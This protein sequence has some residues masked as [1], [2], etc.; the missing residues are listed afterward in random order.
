MPPFFRIFPWYKFHPFV[1][2]F[3]ERDGSTFLISLLM[4]HPD[5]HAVYERFAV[6]NQKG[7]DAEAQLA[8]A[9][10][11]FTPPLFSRVAAAGFKTKLVDIQDPDGFR[12]LLREKKCHIIHMYRRN[13][14]KAV[15]SRINARRL[16]EEVG[17]WNLYNE[18]DR[19]PPMLI[20]LHEFDAYLHERQRAVVDLQSFV[21][22]LQLPTLRVCYED[23]LTIRDNVLQEI[24][25]FLQV[26]PK[27]LVSK[28]IK[29]TSDNLRDVILNYD[30]LK[31][32]YVGTA[33]EDMFEEV[34]VQPLTD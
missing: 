18:K 12:L 15:V 19:M 4:S 34:I 2:L 9:R 25:D 20:D 17:T 22:K 21:D 16:H 31:A 5:I 1:I 29:H 24:F 14:V 8:W 30:E 27:P 6:M 26:C 7:D 33:Y 11:F 28:S 10:N 3:I 32:D 23:L 13:H